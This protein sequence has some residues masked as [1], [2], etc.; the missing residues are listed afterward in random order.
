V[1]LYDGADGAGERCNVIEGVEKI[2]SPV[3]GAGR[4]MFRGKSRPCLY[5][6]WTGRMHKIVLFAMSGD[7]RGFRGRLMRCIAVMSSLIFFGKNKPPPLEAKFEIAHA[8]LIWEITGFESPRLRPEMREKKLHSKSSR[9][10]SYQYY[11]K[12]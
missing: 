1:D 6:R 5:R 2:G 7:D 9:C 8:A 12:P 11:I 4:G 10:S 3:G